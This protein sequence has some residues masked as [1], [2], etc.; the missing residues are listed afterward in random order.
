MRQTQIH[1]KG[2]NEID[3]ESIFAKVQWKKV[4]VGFPHI[5]A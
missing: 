4:E 3:L 1:L 5:P 2:P